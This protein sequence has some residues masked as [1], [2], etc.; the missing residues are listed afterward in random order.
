M[1]LLTKEKTNWKFL[2]IVV[3]VAIPPLIRMSDN[4][5]RNVIKI[6]L[7]LPLICANLCTLMQKDRKKKGRKEGS[8][9]RQ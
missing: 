6:I 9:T 7:V 2:I 5:I 3:I 8:F 1:S 4:M